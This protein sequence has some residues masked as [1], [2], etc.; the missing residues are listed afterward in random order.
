MGTINLFN[1]VKDG[2]SK[3]VE[4]KGVSVPI[5]ENMLHELI[6]KSDKVKDTNLTI[7]NGVIS[8][9]G[10]AEVEKM[11][12]KKDIP[13]SIKLLPVKMEN[14]EIHFQIKE[15]KPVNFEFLNKRIFTHP[16]YFM[17]K[18]FH[19]AI[20]KSMTSLKGKSF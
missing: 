19:S 12:I 14:R 15:F 3:I 17:F 16:P 20:L 7:K 8:I 10:K 11:L 2:L 6:K 18:G 4:E 9:T 1:K 13:F 5:Y